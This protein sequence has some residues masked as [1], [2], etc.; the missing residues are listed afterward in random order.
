MNGV[1]REFTNIIP[2]EIDSETKF[3]K[4][5]SLRALIGVLA[6]FFV[7]QEFV[8][9]VHPTLQLVYSIFSAVLGV[10]LVLPTKNPDKK[11]YHCMYLSFIKKQQVIKP[12][13]KEEA[14]S[15]EQEAS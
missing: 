10:F 4:N 5:I 9:L 7:T 1:S 15:F 11:I 2:G 3:A 8:G 13:D 14:R 6:V 12:I